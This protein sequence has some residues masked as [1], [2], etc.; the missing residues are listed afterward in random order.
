MADAFICDCIR[1]PI[2]RYGGSLSSIRADD[3]AA[4]V[5]D[6]DDS[7]RCAAISFASVDELL[8]SLSMF[9]L[10]VDGELSLAIKANKQLRHPIVIRTLVIILLLAFINLISLWNF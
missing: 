3:L 8:T 6:L 10:L 4:S 9:S 7:E 5:V 2:G 1:T